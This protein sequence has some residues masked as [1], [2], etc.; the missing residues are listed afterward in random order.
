MEAV[1]LKAQSRKER[2]RIQVKKLRALGQVPAV[3]YGR[4]NVPKALAVD[5]KEFE[6][7]IHH[8]ASETVMVNLNLDGGD[9]GG[10]LALVQEVQHHPLTGKILH[11]DFREVSEDEKV[12]VNVPLETRGEAIGVKTGGG[13]LEHVVFQIKICALPK[14]LPE[15]I[16]V[17]VTNLEAGK[18]LHLGEIP[19]PEGVEVLGDSG[20]P[21]ISISQPR[22]PKDGETDEGASK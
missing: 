17:D 15:V 19:L 3:L 12:I 13:L 7:L 10:H 9:A 6:R 1:A 16:Y 8:S 14:Y 22:V 11:V 5:E 20:I 4:N 2:K 21:V 18:T